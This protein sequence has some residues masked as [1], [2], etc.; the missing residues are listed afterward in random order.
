MSEIKI[1][2]LGKICLAQFG[3]RVI[4]SLESCPS[5]L[6]L[7]AHTFGEVMMI[8]KTVPLPKVEERLWK[9]PK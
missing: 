1:S 9:Q 4:P 6:L 2:K 8:T 3:G 7:E 5:K